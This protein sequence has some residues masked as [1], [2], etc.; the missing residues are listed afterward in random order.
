MYIILNSNLLQN[1][2][3]YI[4]LL[5]HVLASGLGHLQVVVMVAKNWDQNMSD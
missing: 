2:F 4:L 1:L 5:R 3:I